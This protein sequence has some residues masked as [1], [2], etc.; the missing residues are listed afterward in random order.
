MSETR[1]LTILWR[2]LEGSQRLAIIGAVLYLPVT[3]L[4]IAQPLIIAASVQYGMIEK[5]MRSV[6]FLGSVFIVAAITL[7]S[8]EYLQGL[9]LQMAGQRL[10]FNLRNR[11]FKK[12]Q[13]LTMGFL[14]NTP[15]GTIITRLT[16][17]AESVAELFSMGAVQIIGDVFF[18]VAT[19]VMLFVVDVPLTL[20]SFT[21]LPLLALGMYGFRRWTK[22]AFVKVRYVLSRLNSFLQEYLSG[23]ATLQM[24]NRVLLSRS[25]FN[26]LNQDF[27]R[28]NRQA[29]FLDAAIFSFV[30]AMSYLT[31]AAVLWGAFDL[32]ADGVLQFGV[33]VAFIE[34]LSRF[35][36]P[37]REL[38]NRAVVFASGMVSLERIHQTESWPE[39]TNDMPTKDL[40]LRQ[41]IEF[42]DV[43]FSYKNG[44]MALRGLSFK[45]RLGER[46]ALVGRTGSGKST[47]L[48]LLHRFYE[49]N[50]GEIRIDGDNIA[51]IS[52]GDLRKLICVVPQ[53]VFLFHGT[54]RAN[55]CFG[56]S[57]AHDEEIWRA[58][59]L[60]QMKDLVQEKGGL[61]LKVEPKGRN[62][63]YGER[64]LLSIARAIIA[65][66]QVLVLDEATA[67]V[68]T[69]TEGKLQAATQALIKD[70]SALIVAH[71]LST[72]KDADRI[73]VLDRGVVVESGN[74]EDLMKKSGYYRELIEAQ[75]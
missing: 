72:I 64:Q 75:R 46:I 31:T 52:L 27:L 74:H 18:L 56:K 37:L 14:D 25:E 34:A 26:A 19:I 43:Q 22:S 71:R 3:L 8:L 36:Q 49:P 59:E 30:D 29:V 1:L 55:M 65:N 38:S 48:K 44:E 61:D 42:D 70:R 4:N 41:A 6:L 5:S 60:T 63:S 15:S 9:C 66:P 39:E 16:N 73:L 54:L 40:R 35:F 51:H 23:L 24:A 53:E 47:V 7:A 68:D 67:G 33:L 50:C 32:R 69:L 12:I 13:K 11:S 45:L 10:V 62:F 58:L 57:N 20:Y 2:N 28:T 21:M 17:D